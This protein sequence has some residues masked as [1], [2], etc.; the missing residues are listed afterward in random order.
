MSKYNNENPTL[1]D[2]Y[3]LQKEILTLVKENDE[4][5]TVQQNEI[6]FKFQQMQMKMETSTM[7]G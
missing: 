5:N 6:N 7:T 3:D 2:I 1:K 4:R